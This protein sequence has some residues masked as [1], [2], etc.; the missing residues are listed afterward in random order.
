MKVIKNMIIT[1]NSK[2]YLVE[3]LKKIG[4]NVSTVNTQ[5]LP[6][7]ANSTSLA[8]APAPASSIAL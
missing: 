4:F 1:Q 7:S 2:H 8:E 6:E 5:S 3:L